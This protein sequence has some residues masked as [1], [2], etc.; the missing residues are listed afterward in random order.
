MTNTMWGGR[1]AASPAQIMEEINASI[2]FDKRLWRHDIL[3]SKAHVA[4]LGATG[5]VKP[6]E[7]DEIA[8]GLDILELTPSEYLTQNEIDAARTVRQDYRNVQ[9]QQQIVWPPSFALARAY[10][11]QLERSGGLAADRIAAA[12]QALDSAEQSSDAARAEAL[13]ALATELHGIADGA[14]EA[15][16]VHTLATAV[17]ELAGA[18][19]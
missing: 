7:A 13:N 17:E 12:R 19:G 8:R 18:E 9:G 3:A 11:D 15:A 16:K 10:L 2:D 14:G 6:S 5:I 4:M 1:F